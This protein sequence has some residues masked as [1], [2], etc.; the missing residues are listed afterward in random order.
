MLESAR[1]PAPNR[2]AANARWN[3][4]S[5]DENFIASLDCNLCRI[6]LFPT[7]GPGKGGE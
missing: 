7:N 6:V 5:S 2:I 1:Y 3:A 4:H